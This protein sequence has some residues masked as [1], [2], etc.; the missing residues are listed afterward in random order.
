MAISSSKLMCGLDPWD[1]APR[2]CGPL[3]HNDAAD[4]FGLLSGDT[5]GACGINDWAAPEKIDERSPAKPLPPTPAGKDG[6]TNFTVEQGQITFDAEGNDNPKSLYFS[7]HLHHPSDSSGVTI[8][9]GYDMKERKAKQVSDD[10]AAAGVPQ[11]L[12]DKFAKGAGLSE[13][14]ADEFVA[15]NRDKLGNITP[16][17]QKQL[18]ELA[19]PV[20]LKDA[21]RLYDKWTSGVKGSVA[22]MDLSQAVRDVLVDLRYQ[23]AATKARYLAAA[24]GGTEDLIEIIASQ[25][26]D[27]EPGRHRIAYLQRFGAT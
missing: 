20:Y 12:A 4:P 1:L 25:L 7:R 8:G 13:D 17:A 2:T 21:K 24:K 22:W 3:G 16:E 6:G 18:F 15:D 27:Y 14:D 23:G 11:T 19:Y 10:L 26:K 5:P 9:R